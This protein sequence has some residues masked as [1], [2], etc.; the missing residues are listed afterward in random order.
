MKEGFNHFS[1]KSVVLVVVVEGHRLLSYG[2]IESFNSS[3]CGSP[4]VWLMTS[5]GNIET[6]IEKV[7]PWALILNFEGTKWEHTARKTGQ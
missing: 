1:P 2:E 7:I 5:V 4:S 3:L 6:Q